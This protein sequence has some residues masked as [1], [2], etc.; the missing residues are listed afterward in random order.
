MQQLLTGRIRL[1]Q[2]E[3]TTEELAAVR[4]VEKK[5]NWQFNEA[6]VISV[7]AKHFDA[8][9]LI[10]WGPFDA[11]PCAKAVLEDL[12][13]ELANQLE[14]TA[15]GIEWQISKLKKMGVLERIGPAR[16]GHWK[17]LETKDE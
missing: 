13:A 3:T 10:R 8:K 9:E 4:P 14:I 11:A 6:V 5:Y 16:G 1:V 12:D 17:V 7:L 15:K 2:S